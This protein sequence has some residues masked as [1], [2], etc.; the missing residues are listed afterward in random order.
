MP[1]VSGTAVELKLYGAYSIVSNFSGHDR[2][3][4]HWFVEKRDDPIGPYKQ[5]I[6]DYEPEKC[7]YQEGFVDECF[8][9]EEIEQLREYVAR[10]HDDTLYIFEIDLP[11]P[12]PMMPL[13]AIGAA[14]ICQMNPQGELEYTTLEDYYM[15]DTEDKYDLPFKCW[16]YYNLEEPATEKDNPPWPVFQLELKPC[17]G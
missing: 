10:V 11:L 8:T 4:F 15:L 7:L 14:G 12:G 1:N 6:K 16:A 5:L 13:G 9:K 2:V 3:K 17:P